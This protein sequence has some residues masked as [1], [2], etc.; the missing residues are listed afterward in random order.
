[1]ASDLLSVD[2]WLAAQKYVQSAAW[3]QSRSD[4]CANPVLIGRV[5]AVIK[6]I[7]QCA[8][9]PCGPIDSARPLSSVGDERPSCRRGQCAAASRSQSA[10]S[11]FT[12][13][14]PKKP[15]R[16]WRTTLDA[17]DQERVQGRLHAVLGT[18][19]SAR[20]FGSLCGVNTEP[21]FDHYG[22]PDDLARQAGQFIRIIGVAF[23]AGFLGQSK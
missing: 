13:R 4:A 19:L 22:V 15:H 17:V 8:Y 21:P 16:A 18:A 2:S 10:N 6:L 14:K 12:L 3:W 9:A 5:A 7:G 11:R 1:V 20:R 23:L